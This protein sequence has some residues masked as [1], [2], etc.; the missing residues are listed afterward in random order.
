MFKRIVEHVNAEHNTDDPSGKLLNEFVNKMAD[1]FKDLNKDQLE[2]HGF[3]DDIQED[4]LRI[5]TKPN[6][7]DKS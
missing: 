7:E 4:L 5:E 1:E 3:K 2:Y 6:G